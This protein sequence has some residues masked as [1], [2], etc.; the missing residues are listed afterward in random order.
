MSR[1]QESNPLALD[2]Q[3][4]FS[5]Y[6]ATNAMVRA[7]RPLLNELNLTYPQYLAMLVLWENEG[8]SV[9]T[10]GDKLHLDSGTLTPLLKRLETKGLISRGRSE[11]DERARVLHTSKEGRELKQRAATIPEQMRCKLSIKPDVFAELKRLCDQ[12]YVSLAQVEQK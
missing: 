3:V 12:A 5:L 8:L 2:N 1:D 4:C 6:S 7:Y 9:K 10:L 11:T